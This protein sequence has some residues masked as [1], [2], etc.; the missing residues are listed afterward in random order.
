MTDGA[1]RTAADG[2]N[3]DGPNANGPTVYGPTIDAQTRCIHY[4]TVLDVVAMRF[5]CC[6]RYYPCH[7]CHEETAGH[8]AELW[9][10]AERSSPAVLCGVCAHELSVDEYLALHDV[11]SPCCPAC[12]AGFNAGCRLHAHLYFEGAHPG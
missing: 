3:V 11:E 8:P 6:D 12:G 5:H 4:G 10:V 2:P 1:G 7:L 9:P